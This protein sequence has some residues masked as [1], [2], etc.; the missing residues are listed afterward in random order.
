MRL[1]SLVRERC[2]PWFERIGDNELHES[3]GLP[4]TSLA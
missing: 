3:N 4:L 1:A 2:R